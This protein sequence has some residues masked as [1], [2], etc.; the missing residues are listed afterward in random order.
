MGELLVWREATIA[1]IVPLSPR[2]RGVFLRLPLAG[3]RAGQHLEVRLTAPDGYSAQRDYS[4]ASAPGA[5]LV[6]LAIERLPEGEVSAWFH[7]VAEVGDVLEVR[8]PIGGH[9]VWSPPGED[10]DGGPLLLVGGGSGVAPLMAM[11]RQR[12]AVAPSL[13]TL[14]VVS[15]RT[16]ADLLWA[17]ELEGIAAADP[18]FAF[19]AA[20]TR[21]PARR[22]QDVSGRL[23]AAAWTAILA[24]WGARPAHVFVCGS[25]AFVEA[26]ATR[27]LAAGVPAAAIRTERFGGAA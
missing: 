4:I 27:L 23:D 5:D 1:R 26:A 25:N 18:A 24:D 12:A 16:W 20:V 7:E 17:G 15:A 3:Q 21:E 9:F 2:V 19:R 10:G 11:A 13:P 6:E 14:L 8:G 22:P